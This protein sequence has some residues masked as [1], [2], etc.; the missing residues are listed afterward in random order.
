MEVS[1][2]VQ[3]S[4]PQITLSW[5][6]D[7]YAAPS[8]YTVYRKSPGATSWGSATTLAGTAT[9]YTDTSVAVGTAYEYQIT[10]V[11]ATYN[12]YGYI[13][14]GINAPLV[15]GRGK[16]ILVVDNTYAAS[17]AAEL[18]RLQQDLA[19][20][21]WTVLRHD[22][23]RAS[24]VA[25]VKSLIQADYNAD[26]ANV[27]AVFLFGHV[28]VPYSG[29]LN[30]DGHL[31][32]Y[33][34]WPA[35]A[36]Y[37]T[38]TG[39]W[40][41]NSVN[42]VQTVNT[43][44][45]DA[46]RL[47]NVPGD[48][49][50]DQ[51]TIPAAVDI[52]V[53][54]VD[55]ANMPGRLVWGGLPSFPSEPE[56]L[57]QYLNKDHTF[58]F[59]L[60]TAQRRGVVADYFG[61]RSGEA[62]A[63][64]AFRN[65]APFF[66]ANNID[67]LNLI[68]NDAKGVW[69]PTLATNAYLWAYGCGA[70]SYTTCGG[71]G[72]TGLYNDGSTTEIVAN[73]VKA[74]FV[75]LFGSWLGDWDHEDNL[76]RS[77][78][79]TPTHGLVCAW[80]GRPHWF[81][82]PMAL[83]ETIGYT[84]RLT[85]NNT[86]LYQNQINSAAGEIHVALMGDPTLR[87][88]PV[89]PP[90]TLSGTTNATSIT[91]NWTASPDSVLGYYVYRSANAFGPFTRL[92]GSLLSGSSFVDNNP[93]AGAN[94]YMVRALKLETSG[95]GT[96]T[97]AS[98]GLFWSANS[99]VVQGGGDTTPPSGTN[100]PPV[101]IVDGVN[102]DM[103]HA[104]DNTLHVLS[105]TVLE[106]HLIN[107][108]AL[109]P[110]TVTNWNFVDSSG[111][112]S[113]PA[114]SKFTVTVNGQAVTVQSAGF[115]RRPLYAPLATYD[116][117]IDNCIYLNL[118][119][120][121][122]DNQTVTVL[123]PD[124]T[125]WPAT[126]LFSTTVNPLRYSPALHVNQEGYMP[127]FPKKAS[128]GYYLGS[129]GE[130][131]IPTTSFTIVDATSGATVFQGTMTQR[132]D[133]GYTYTPAP[134]QKVYEADFSSL[135]TPGEYRLLVPGL[136]ASLPFLIHDGIAIAFARAYEL[137][138]YHQ[139]CGTSNSLP[140][141][142]F[143]HDA[144]H[145]APASVPTSASSAFAFT[146]TTVSNYAI[147]ANADNPAQI[148]PKLISPAA[149][150]YPFVRGGA[151]DVSGGHHDAGDYSKYTCNSAMVVHHLM[152]AVD[153]L[154]GVASLDNL[155]IP[156]SGDGISDVMQE[157]KWEADFLAKLQDTDGGFY[158]LVYPQYRE[159]ENNV[160]PDHG[161]PQVVWPKNSSATAASVAALAQCAS[162]PLFK[163]TYPQA[164]SNYL[165]KAKLGWQFL[166]NAVARYGKS[167][168]YQKITHYGDD[169]TDRDELAWAACEMFLAT[170]DPAIQQTLESWFPDPTDPA[171]FRWGW[172]RL[173]ACY[174][175]AVRDYAFAVKSGRLQA[176][177][178]DSAY[179]AKCIT[180]VTNA[181]NDALTWSQHGAYGSSFPDQTKVVRGAGWYFSGD[182]AYDITVAYQF[183]PNPAYLDALIRN[184]NYEGGCNPV[185]VSYVTGLGWKRQS[186]IVDQYSQNDRRA[187]PKDGVPLGNIQQGFVFVNTYGSELTEL[188]YPSDNASTAP[189]PYYDRWGDAFN[190]TTEFTVQQSVRELAS[191]AWLAAQ[192]SLQTQAW[193]YAA[194]QIQPPATLPLQGS[195]VTVSL[196]VPGLDLSGARVV[197]EAQGAQPAYGTSFT[198]TPT[199]Y[200]SAW[201]EA[202]AQWPD[203]RRVFA[204][205][206]LF[207]TNSLPAVSVAA[208]VPTA[209]IG[210]TNYGVFTFTRTGGT[211]GDLVVNY[212]LGGT[213]IKWDD[214]RRPQGDMPVSITIPS[215][216]A[217]A[218][219][220]IMAVTN[221]TSANPE[222]VLLTVS[223][224]P[225]YN[226]GSAYSATVTVLPAGSTGIAGSGVPSSIAPAP[227]GNMTISWASVAGKT[228]R[229]AYKNNLMDTAWTNL[230]GLITATS[231]TTA[232]TDTTA[233][234]AK[235][236][237]YMVYVTN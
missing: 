171:T 107:T 222:T 59:K 68:Y 65:F 81:A 4:P 5:P 187:L 102:L 225:A 181:G 96:Y 103:P 232:W 237:Y 158:F 166:T 86:G 47:T 78:L 146:W 134:Y 55:L 212:S 111:N 141:T 19:G 224:A 67:N 20:D 236:R 167:G 35:D 119:T 177:Q 87:M 115:K 14:A 138:L 49:K 210:S 175:N 150:L 70:G 231:A 22:V 129:L 226:V 213:A 199:N 44:P 12:G 186:E 95:S 66:G 39:S 218:T 147:T 125:V 89:A 217:S 36:F 220:T 227:G 154:P 32:H 153:S 155:G 84:A 21:G 185:N 15:E 71:L 163:A 29:L 18:T 161:D 193:S 118:A 45:A 114:L 188:C 192:T 139:R 173:F 93:P 160:L 201:V 24:S 60:M 8:S 191:V 90:G 234:A 74:V 51:T 130:M 27:K 178:V 183:N 152:F 37:G 104:G 123:N 235:Q 144:C 26:P 85:Q 156:E 189:Y 92:S 80:S 56:L 2:T 98:Q 184:L 219:L 174:G 76:M 140:F 94:T 164:A 63:A 34:A 106:L 54:R 206:N 7:T 200:G 198:F 230:S 3:V 205:T 207:T 122:A 149:Q 53:G 197:W 211:A 41:D 116:L 208:T 180:T 88:H 110:A 52:Q 72:N 17:L 120:P 176:S 233:G 126:M 11:T 25:S 6:Q 124:Q 215:G 190:V 57:R 112:L 165:A 40:S 75:N 136:G 221:E 61:V 109:D 79:A 77:I 9:S 23:G 133:T 30:P 10:K 159:Y 131:T 209:T 42:Y 33:G 229:V 83:G 82:H 101:S 157:A 50:Y 105:P 137:G 117:R 169:F 127:A 69:I 214:Y 46:A 99:G 216:S 143:T 204:A 43:D 148:A 100:P 97:N 91:L 223:T 16:V 194:S 1:A 58:R 128:A 162:S 202:E 168:I 179:L 145:V 113:L 121:V 142:R 31:D 196:Q 108:K 151:V 135:T 182:Q 203:G 38:M 170:G 172:W 195:P 62:F 228:Y 64:S 48:G 73:D 28:P 13:Q 132:P